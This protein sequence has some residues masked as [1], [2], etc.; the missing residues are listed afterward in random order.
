MIT[1]STKTGQIVMCRIVVLYVIFFWNSYG[2]YHGIVMHFVMEWLWIMIFCRIIA[3]SVILYWNAHEICNGIAMEF[4]NAL[5]NILRTFT[6]FRQTCVLKLH[7]YVFAKTETSKNY[8]SSNR[9]CDF[10]KSNFVESAK[11]T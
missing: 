4:A 10:I 2:S 7:S 9:F 3:L 6:P 5:Q 8:L 11:F 1:L